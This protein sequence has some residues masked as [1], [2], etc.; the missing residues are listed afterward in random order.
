MRLSTPN[1]QGV[2]RINGVDSLTNTLI[3]INRSRR[4]T[5]TKALKSKCAAK[6]IQCS[7]S[8][9]KTVAIIIYICK[10]VSLG[11]MIVRLECSEG[12][13]LIIFYGVKI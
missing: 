9:K 6:L 13:S 11:G 4:Q 3:T 12:S 10:T 7:Q 2:I 5:R 1:K 8:T